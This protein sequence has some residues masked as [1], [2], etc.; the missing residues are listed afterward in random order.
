MACDQVLTCLIFPFR[1]ACFP[2]KTNR[3]AQWVHLFSMDFDDSRRFLL[4]FS[5]KLPFSGESMHRLEEGPLH[6]TTLQSTVKLLNDDRRHCLFF[7]IYVKLTNSDRQH[8]HYLKI[9]RR[10]WGL[11]IKGPLGR[12]EYVRP[13]VVCKRSAHSLQS[14]YSVLATL[15]CLAGGNEAT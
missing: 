6:Y 14:I 5:L 8:C 7:K 2:I 10:H 13:F 12:L 1:W 4:C 3:K 9:V 15:I 11:P